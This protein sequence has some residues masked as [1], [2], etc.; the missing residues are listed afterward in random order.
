MARAVVAYEEKRYEDALAALREALELA[1][2][3]LDALYYMGLTLVAQGRLD[4]AVGPLEQARAR[5][6]RDTATLFQLGVVYF[7][8]ERYDQAQPLLE[9]AFAAKPTLENLGYYVGFLRY[10]RGDYQGA[11]RAFG[12]G[13]SRDPDVQQLTRFYS[14]LALRALGL[15][16][17]AAAEIEQALRLQPASP[18]TGPAERVRQAVVAAREGERRFHA[19]LRLGGFYDDNVPVIPEVS[20]DPS[21]QDL[22][23]G[24]RESFGELGAL[25]LEYSFLRIES[26][27]VSAAYS[28]FATYNNDL[29]D[30]NLV[31]HLGGLTGAYRGT[32]A[33]LPYY[34]TLQYTFDYATLGG[35]EFIQRHIV[36]PYLSVAESPANLTSLQLRY[37]DKRFLNEDTVEPAERR[38]GTNWMAGVT[39]LFR[40]EQDR[41]LIRIGYQWDLDD[42][43]GRNYA[44]AG[45]RIVAGM[46]YTLPVGGVRFNYDFDVHLRDYKHRNTILPADAPGTKARSDTE[47]NHVVALTVPLPW[48]L[49]LVTQY[50]FTDARSNLD[51]FTYKRNVVYLLLIWTY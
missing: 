20:V 47:S 15:P 33:A 14:G 12:E 44:Y 11:L 34:L 49:S 9:E 29:P 51:L 39:H 42:T 32:L 46:Q 26:L 18:L 36:S 5:A 45:H 7:A 22:R 21:I 48:S 8:L 16:E 13:T 40:F 28:F 38:T 19:E 43:D 41:H 30:F 31:D 4:Q 24:R 3:H 2:N 25:R 23:R 37:Q 10:R 1:P 27:D 17:R 35:D 50:Q 6:P